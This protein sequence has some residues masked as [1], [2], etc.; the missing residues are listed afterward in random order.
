MTKKNIIIILRLCIKRRENT[1]YIK[2]QKKYKIQK[3]TKKI[4]KSK[5]TK[6]QDITNFFRGF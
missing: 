6:K 1:K 5:I 3:N 2:T 4:Q